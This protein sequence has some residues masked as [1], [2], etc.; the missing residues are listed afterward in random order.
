MLLPREGLGAFLDTQCVPQAAPVGQTLQGPLGFSQLCLCHS[1]HHEWE[2][3]G[4]QSWIYLRKFPGMEKL[5][6]LHGSS[7]GIN[8]HFCP[9]FTP[10]PACRACCTQDYLILTAA[11]QA[12]EFHSLLFMVPT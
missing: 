8:A 1:C 6:H 9:S 11:T 7:R 4:A 12:A 10:S 3:A 5:I 2:V